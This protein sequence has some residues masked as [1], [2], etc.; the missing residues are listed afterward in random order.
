MAIVGRI[1]PIKQQHI[2]LEAIR[3]L[4]GKGI[5]ASLNIYGEPGLSE[6][7]QNYFR[8][9]KKMVPSVVRIFCNSA[10]TLLGIINPSSKTMFLEI[11]F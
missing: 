1:Q 4:L 6:D 8:M 10:T 11:F 2:V 5:M 9:L 3:V 7:D